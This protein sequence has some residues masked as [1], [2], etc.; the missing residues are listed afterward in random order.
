MPSSRENIKL[1][2]GV[3]EK[4]RSGVLTQLIL[5]PLSSNWTPSARCWS[6][7]RRSSKTCS[8]MAGM[9]SPSGRQPFSSATKLKLVTVPSSWVKLWDGTTTHVLYS[10]I[11]DQTKVLINRRWVNKM[12]NVLPINKQRIRV[13]RKKKCGPFRNVKNHRFP[14]SG[15]LLIHGFLA[16][17]TNRIMSVPDFSLQMST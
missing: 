10:Q 4:S 15:K 6:A 16:N 14:V 2:K 5:K 7:M 9:P 8:G 11:N 1:Q 17:N 12:I 3:V 13:K